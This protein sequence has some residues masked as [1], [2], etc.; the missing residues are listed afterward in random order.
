MCIY[1]VTNTFK[2]YA[3]KGN[4]KVKKDIATIKKS[5]IHDKNK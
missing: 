4:I 2:Q 3:N 1:K 5:K